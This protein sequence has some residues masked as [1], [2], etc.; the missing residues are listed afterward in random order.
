MDISPETSRQ[1]RRRR[2]AAIR[3]LGD[4][5]E[6][7][8]GL[9]LRHE[10]AIG[11]YLAQMTSSRALAEDLLQET[12]LVAWRER[13]RIPAGDA[14]R[15]WLFGIARHRALDALRRRRRGRDALARLMHR[16]DRTSHAPAVTEALAMRDLLVRTL[17]PEDR[18]LFVLRYVHGFDAPQLAE[19][20]GM[21]AEAVRKRLE[22]AGRRL[23][24]AHERFETATT[25][26][27]EEPDDA[28]ATA[29]A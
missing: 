23:A 9:V 14:A 15:A 27:T 29:H 26:T 2:G 18:S 24:L 19:L 28:H 10:R 20:T 21:S 5:D 12:F 6:R 7:F 22:R 3:E 11:A 13:E 8:R 1:G 25:T 16:F 4:Q 17:G